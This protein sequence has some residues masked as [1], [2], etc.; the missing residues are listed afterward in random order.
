MYTVKLSTNGTEVYNDTVDGHY[1]LFD[2]LDPLTEYSITIGAINSV[3][4]G[5]TETINTYTL[6]EYSELAR[7]SLKI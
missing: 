4:V 7:V 3:G 5:W 6:G 1:Y 2:E